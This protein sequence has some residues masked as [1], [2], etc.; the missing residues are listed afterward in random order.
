MNDIQDNLYVFIISKHN[1]SDE[2]ITFSVYI[3]VSRFFS[4]IEAASHMHEDD[5]KWE[6]ENMKM[7]NISFHYC[8]FLFSISYT[9][10][11]REMYHSTHPVDYGWFMDSNEF[12]IWINFNMVKCFHNWDDDDQVCMLQFHSSFVADK[13]WDWDWKFTLMTSSIFISAF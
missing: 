4:I 7:M 13:N 5:V 6:H 12:L 3:F 10:N 2:I 1:L 11:K 8:K 9:M